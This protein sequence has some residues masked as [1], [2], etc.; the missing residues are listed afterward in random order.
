MHFSAAWD[1]E[2]LP[3]PAVQAGARL[4][5]VV[6]ASGLTPGVHHLKVGRINRAD[7]QNLRSKLD[8]RFTSIEVDVDGVVRELDTDQWSRYGVIR[9][10]LDDG[11]TGSTTRR[12]GGFLVEGSQDIQFGLNPSQDGELR[13]QVVTVAGSPSRFSVA[14]DGEEFQV[15]A[16][17]D[18]RELIAPIGAGP[19]DVEIRVD[20]EDLGLSLW[21]APVFRPVHGESRGSVV[22]VTLDTT[23]RD[24]L[25]VYGGA[26]AASPRI[27]DL[28]ER[29]TVYENAWSTSPWTLP[30]HA[31]IFTG[32]YP[33]RHGAA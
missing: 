8:C 21:G 27:A 11:V 26:A 22:L 18:A 31:S 10:F 19:S 4:R 6:P 16:G 14:V 20:G 3:G 30:S 32:L 1:G 7:D 25:S 28:A 5:F 17:S 2:E 23:R 12:R 33:T 29:S 15:T 9:A 24:V 13:F